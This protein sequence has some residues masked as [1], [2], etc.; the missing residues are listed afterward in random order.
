[1]TR[2]RQYARPRGFIAALLLAGCA[3]G[4]GCASA[5]IEDAVPTSAE[6]AAQP[7]AFAAPGEYPN[8]NVIPTPAAEQITP[9]ERAAQTA[10]LRSR[11]ESLQA[12]GGGGAA[13]D[14][15]AELRRLGQ[16]H[17]DQALEMIESE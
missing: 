8:L 5:K 17:A 12:R 14:D 10:E 9:Q 16:R 6:A 13:T 11:R 3:A 7:Q 15:R 1:M 4:A 2:R